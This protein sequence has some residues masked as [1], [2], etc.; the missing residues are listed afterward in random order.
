MKACLSPKIIYP[1]IEIIFYTQKTKVY[2]FDCQTQKNLFIKEQ[3]NIFPYTRWS[4]VRWTG[5]SL[6]FRK[7]LFCSREITVP[8]WKIFLFTWWSR[9][10]STGRGILKVS[11]WST[12]LCQ[13]ISDKR[14]AKTGYWRRTELPREI[15][16]NGTYCIQFPFITGGK[17]WIYIESVEIFMLPMKS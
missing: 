10:K 1:V 8:Y 2:G 6:C 17:N 4:H 16:D 15:R 13:P 12:I 5:E 3:N 11:W 9:A 7:K 14:V